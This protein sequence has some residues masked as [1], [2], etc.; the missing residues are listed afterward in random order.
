MTGSR[1]E[2]KVMDLFRNG[3]EEGD[4]IEAMEHCMP[5]LSQQSSTACLLQ[6]KL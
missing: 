3:T 1:A 2:L 4:V 6:W 5:C